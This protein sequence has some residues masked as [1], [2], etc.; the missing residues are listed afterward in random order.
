MLKGGMQQWPLTTGALIDHAA[1][2]HGATEVVSRAADG[3]VVR[4]HWAGIAANARAAAAGLAMLGAERGDRVATLAWNRA[5]HL[6]L[7]YAI[8]AG[9]MVLHTVNPRLHA[10]QVRYVTAHGGA[11]ILCVDPDLLPIVTPILPLLPEVHTV[12]VL[13]DIPADLPD[14]VRYLSYAD[15]LGLAPPLAEW[16][17]LDENDAAS[18]C[19]TSG[20][21]GD[22]KG[23]L[24]SHR[25]ILLHAF[26]ICAADSMAL[27]AC[28]TVLLL[29]PMFHVNSWG[30]PFGAAMCGAKLVLPGNQLDGASLLALLRDER[31]TFSLGVPT[32]WFMLLDHIAANTDAEARAALRLDRVFTGGASTPRALVQRFRDLLGVETMQAWGMT[33]TSPVAAVCRPL[34]CQRDL[35]PEE[36]L[37]LRAKAGRGVFGVELRVEDEDGR[38]L[39]V[40]DAA[41]G[42]LKVRGHW[43]IDRYFG[44]SADAVDADGWFG[45]GDVGRI[46]AHGFLQITDR[47]KDVIKSGGEWIS[48]IELENAAAAH[49]AVAEAAVVGVA[50]PSWQERP[51]LLV[52]LHPDVPFDA[53]DMRAHLLRHVARWWLPDDIVVVDELPHT[54]SGKVVKAALRERYRDHLS[55]SAAS[56]APSSA[57]GGVEVKLGTGR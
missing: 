22:P 40:G 21:T 20:T 15:L 9:G 4:S 57:S 37:D 56:S 13:G 16:P 38:G 14:G 32:V 8:S 50:H 3:R 36:A 46:D 49:P 54:A 28:D 1:R 35:P 30:V 11:R 26:G 7:Y 23:C 45:T 17:V 27:S 19:Y 6:E 48:S 44:A 12:V 53:D 51:L 18:L 47:S 29:P 34:G 42:A 33:E 5:A 43:V 39:P 55:S 31:V 10:D 2:Q 52:R 24:Y 41:T 25:S